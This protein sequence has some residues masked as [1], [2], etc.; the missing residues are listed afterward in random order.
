MHTRSKIGEIM[1]VLDREDVG[2]RLWVQ[3][4]V[5]IDLFEFKVDG[6]PRAVAAAS[7][8]HAKYG[9][10]VRWTP[11]GGGDGVPC[12]FVPLG[13]WIHMAWFPTGVWIREYAGTACGKSFHTRR[14][15]L[16]SR[17]EAACTVG[18]CVFCLPDWRIHDGN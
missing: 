10:P 1:T 12:A 6:I 11:I 4:Q 9:L 17:P 8:L 5:A 3:C 13:F 14:E 18:H 15:P 7:T 16:L 2:T